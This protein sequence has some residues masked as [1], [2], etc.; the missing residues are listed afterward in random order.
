MSSIEVVDLRVELTNGT[1]IVEDVNFGINAGRVLGLVGESGCG[2]TTVALALLAYAKPGS[3]IAAGMVQIDGIDLL[4]VDKQEL[5]RLRGG[6]VAYVPQDPASAL[7][8]AIRVGGQIAEM[9]TTHTR[10][11]TSPDVLIREALRRV[12]LEPAEYFVDRYP[13]Q[14]SGGQQQR[15]AIAMALICGPSLVVLDEPTTGLDVTTQAHVLEVIDELRRERDTALLY[16]SHD[17]GVVSHFADSVAVMYGGRIVEH[18]DT[19]EV[20]ASPRHPYTSKLLAAMPRSDVSGTRPRGI[21]GAAI[22]PSQRP[23]G[24]S[25]APRC[26][27]K[28]TIC[29][30]EVPPLETASGRHAVA[31]FN[32]K[33]PSTAKRLHQ[34]SEIV[35][36]SAEDT[37]PPR[38]LVEDLRA[39]Y[40]RSRSTPESALPALGGVSLKVAQG[41]C[42]AVVGESGSG[43]TTLARCIIGI[44]PPDGGRVLLDGQEV[45]RRA[46]GRSKEQRQRV[47]IVFQN[48]EESLNPKHTVEQIVA[49]PLAQFF[50]LSRKQARVRA[51]ETLDLVRLDASLAYRYP[52]DLSGGEKQRVAIARAIAAQPQLLICDEITSALDVS[53]QA[54]ILELIADLRKALDMSI[55]FISH[56]LAVVRSIADRI[57]VLESGVVCETGNTDTLFAHQEAEYTR[58]LMTAQK[59]WSLETSAS[60]ATRD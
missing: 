60:M 27:L 49:R 1:A 35:L 4:A 57:I 8:P 20:F 22:A 14:L 43:K 42:L 34:A 6:R 33:T 13:H 31:C 9:L 59:A 3:R 37:E 29:L 54:A 17:L 2:K 52:K 11:Q 50:N 45:A 44:W 46:R 56:D 24:C 18:G 19:A 23:A 21:D 38:L 53:V 55:I 36:E 7:N 30:N 51:A 28:T 26:E 25:F 40:R 12:H 32:W 16:V 58:A 41:E 15:V 47:Q 39:S 10:D 48:P 5:Q